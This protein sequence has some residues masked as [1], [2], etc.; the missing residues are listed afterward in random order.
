MATAGNQHQHRFRLGEATQRLRTFSAAAGSTRIAA[1][2]AMSISWRRRRLYSPA[3]MPV[4][5]LISI[6]SGAADGARPAP[7]RRAAAA[8]PRG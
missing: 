3:A 4:R 6:R 8:P 5:C 7:R 2:P 1:S